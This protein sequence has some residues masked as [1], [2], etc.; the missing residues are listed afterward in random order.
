[1]AAAGRFHHGEEPAI[2]PRTQRRAHRYA[3]AVLTPRRGGQPVYETLHDNIRE[4]KIAATLA[5]NGGE[6]GPALVGITEDIKEFIRLH[7]AH[8]QLV[9]DATEPTAEACDQS[10]VTP[11]Y[12]LCHWGPPAWSNRRKSHLRAAVQHR[13]I[14]GACTGELAGRKGLLLQHHRRAQWGRRPTQACELR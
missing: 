10:A 4:V 11:G 1:M 3:V 6:R 9:G 12:D 13:R 5:R 7:R 14:F 2:R 8:G